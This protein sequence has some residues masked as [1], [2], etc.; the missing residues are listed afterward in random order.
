MRVG[1][2]A[3]G[4]WDGTELRGREERLHFL[5]GHVDAVSAALLGDLVRRAFGGEV[6]GE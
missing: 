5:Q 2:R 4:V 3:F 1:L 6:G